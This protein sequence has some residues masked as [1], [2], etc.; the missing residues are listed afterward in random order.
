MKQIKVGICVDGEKIEEK[1]PVLI[2]MGFESVSITYKTPMPNVD[3]SEL[4]KRVNEI[5]GDRPVNVSSL[6]FYGNPLTSEEDQK[7]LSKLMLHAGE[8][9]TDMVGTFAGALTG[10][11]V[12]E[13]IPKFR[14][15][16]GE[17][18]KQ[19]EDRG[20]KIAFENCLHGGTWRCAT[21][22]IAFHPKA[23]EMMFDAVPS[24]HLGLEW[25]PAHQL[26]QL[27]DPV[28]QLEQWI[29]KVFH[30][31]GKD[32]AINWDF[33]KKNGVSGVGYIAQF[34][35]PGRGETD[36]R[37]IFKILY[38]NHYMGHISLESGH[39]PVY[40]GELELLGEKNTLEYLVWCR[41]AFHTVR[42]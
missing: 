9:G 33:I 40:H 31:H 37:S 19:A 20:L 25:E 39:D 10:R 4:A 16:F 3:F 8:F 36:W 34:R 18:A 23:W 41:D 28:E 27:M 32:A 22:N 17:I 21:E 13:A 6:G 1:L 15:V 29:G 14:S 38:Q 7:A 42:K 26:A 35:N 2:D 30:I 12:E 24:E 11:P 5:I